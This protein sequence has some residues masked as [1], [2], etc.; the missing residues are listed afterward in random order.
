LAQAGPALQAKRTFTICGDRKLIKNKTFLFLL[1]TIIF[2]LSFLTALAPLGIPLVLTM[3]G[4]LAAIALER[5]INL[6][7][8]LLS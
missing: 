6:T 5:L 8:K 7:T 2:V 3:L 1:T 4:V